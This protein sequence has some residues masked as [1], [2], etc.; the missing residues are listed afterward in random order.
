VTDADFALMAAK[1]HQLKASFGADVL[2]SIEYDGYGM[3]FEFKLGAVKQTSAQVLE[4]A[5]SLGLMVKSLGAN[6]YRVEPYA[7]LSDTVVSGGGG[8]I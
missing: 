3:N 1:L 4:H 7:G 2:Q 8:A 6:R 5:R